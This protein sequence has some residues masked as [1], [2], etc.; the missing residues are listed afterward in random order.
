MVVRRNA[1]RT[2]R[3]PLPDRTGRLPGRHRPRHHPS[4]YP[5]LRAQHHAAVRFAQPP[6]PA[7]LLSTAGGWRE[8]DARHHRPSLLLRLHAARRREHAADVRVRSAH[9]YASADL[10]T[11]RV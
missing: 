2:Q 11:C 6:Q 3:G 5:L 10:P 4:T 1:H 8:G 9:R 7:R